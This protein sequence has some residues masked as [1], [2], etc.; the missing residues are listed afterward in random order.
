M[1]FILATYGYW[2]LYFSIRNDS[3]PPLPDGFS[4]EFRDFVRL[5]Y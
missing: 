5:W 2:E 1:I 4:E 3:I